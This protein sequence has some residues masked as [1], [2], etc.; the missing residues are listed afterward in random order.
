M[1]KLYRSDITPEILTLGRRGGGGYCKAGQLTR[2]ADSESLLLWR[3]AM[4]HDELE[5][6]NSCQSMH[7]TADS[8]DGM[9]TLRFCC[10]KACTLAVLWQY[11]QIA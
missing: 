11:S 4:I 5:I 9:R 2:F 7:V 3:G 8:A 6:P 10:G 1:C